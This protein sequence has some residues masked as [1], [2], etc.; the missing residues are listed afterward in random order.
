MHVRHRGTAAEA[1][2]TITSFCNYINVCNNS[3]LYELFSEHAVAMQLASAAFLL[4]LDL[5][6]FQEQRVSQDPESSSRGE[7]EISGLR[8]QLD[9]LY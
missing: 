6:E 1:G 2:F 4:L 9:G 8:K 7:L 5:K 3:K